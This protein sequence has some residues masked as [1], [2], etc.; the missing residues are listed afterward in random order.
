MAS[1]PW[2]SQGLLLAV[3]LLCLL[4]HGGGS[5][6]SPRGPHA[7]LE[8]PRP[9]RRR[10]KEFKPCT[11]LSHKPRCR[12]VL[13][14]GV[15]RADDRLIAPSQPARERSRNMIHSPEVRDPQLLLTQLACRREFLRHQDGAAEPKATDGI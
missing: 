6:R 1:T 13:Q 4:L 2:F 9:R 3:V 11:G 12:E 5:N 15:E 10:F 8:P 14:T 7:P